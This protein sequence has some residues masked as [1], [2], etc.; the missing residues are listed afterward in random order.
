MLR[1]CE[2]RAGR[3]DPN[4]S[5]RS[6]YLYVSCRVLL[7]YELRLY[8]PHVT[9]LQ[10]VEYLAYSNVTDYYRYFTRTQKFNVLFYVPTY[11]TLILIASALF[12]TEGQGDLNRKFSTIQ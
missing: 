11:T 12:V 10:Y 3:K 9:A 5:Q 1:L 6:L 2:K 7:T 8:E 4:V